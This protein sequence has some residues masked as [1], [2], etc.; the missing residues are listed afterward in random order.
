MPSS[1]LFPVAVAGLVFVELVLTPQLRSQALPSASKTRN[2]SSEHGS[3]R[4]GH[5]RDMLFG[6]TYKIP[7]GWVDRTAEMQDSDPAQPTAD[8]A[9]AQVLLGIF[10]RP[11]EVTG[12]TVNSAV[13]IAAESVSS[14]P[15]LKTAADYFGPLEEVVTAKGFKVV[16]EPY[17]FPIGAKQLA[18]EDFTKAMGKLTMQQATLVMLAKGYIVSFTF[19]GGGEDEVEELLEGVSFPTAQTS[20]S[21]HPLHRS[22]SP[23]SPPGK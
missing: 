23:S 21:P 6:F 17:E 15:G 18:R 16:N 5:Y 4:E 9:K 10:E 14:Y 22:S 7:F 11:P 19:L 1:R 3:I 8:P 13:V 2:A 20:G 12:E